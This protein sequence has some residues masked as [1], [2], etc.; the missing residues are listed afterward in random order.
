MHPW[1]ETSRIFRLIARANIW[2][3]MVSGVLVNFLFGEAQKLL[4]IIKIFH[5]TIDKIQKNQKG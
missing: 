2:V 3:S 5:T 4:I 1:I